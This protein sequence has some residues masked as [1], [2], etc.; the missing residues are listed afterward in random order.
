[1]REKKVIEKYE[2]MIILHFERKGSDNMQFIH[3]FT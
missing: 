2:N 3:E 1:M